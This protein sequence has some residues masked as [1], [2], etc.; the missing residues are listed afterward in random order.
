MSGLLQR[1]LDPDPRAENRYVVRG[2]SSRSIMPGSP[3]RLSSAHRLFSAASEAAVACANRSCAGRRGWRRERGG[4]R[5]AADW[6][7]VSGSRHRCAGRGCL[8]RA[9]HTSFPCRTP[10]RSWGSSKQ[11]YGSLIKG[12]IFGARERKRRGEVAKESA[13]KLS[14]DEGLQVLHRHAARAPGRDAVRLNAPSQASPTAAGWTRRQP[15]PG[16]E[17]CASTARSSTPAPAFRLAEL[18][19]ATR[20]AGGLLAVLAEIRYP[21]VASVVLGFRRRR[22]GASLRRI[23]HADS[24][25][26]KASTFWALSFLRRCFRTARPRGHLT[27]DQL[28]WGRALLRNWRRCRRQN[29]RADLRD[30]RVLLG[31][32]GKPTFQHSVLFRKPF[33]STTSAMAGSATLMTDIERERPGAVLRRPLPGRHLAERFDRVRHQY[34]RAAWA[35]HCVRAARARN[36]P[37]CIT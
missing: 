37:G 10:F 21:P 33:R 22:C 36:S 9:I 1:R 20:P 11:R 28:C 29:C 34:G 26:S 6:P 13:A 23:R 14:F 12:Q 7:G 31:V 35:T 8:R 2:T 25:K 19:I 3:V 27:L 32:S 16:S 15:G 5:D 4:V 24:Q 30:L 17:E 18:K